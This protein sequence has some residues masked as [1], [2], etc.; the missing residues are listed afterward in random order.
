[1]PGQTRGP[2][3]ATQKEINKSNAPEVPKGPAPGSEPASTDTQMSEA[4]AAAE[5][6][7][8]KMFDEQLAKITAENAAR[9]QELEAQAKKAQSYAPVD[10]Y[11]DEE[12]DVILIHFLEDGFTAQGATWYRGQEVEVTVG[13]DRWNESLDRNGGTWFSFTERDQMERYDG[14]IMFRRGP[15]PGATYLDAEWAS[16]GP[17]VSELERADE[18]ERRRQRQAPRLPSDFT[19]E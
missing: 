7:I 9:I 17:P 3:K 10:K 4:I 15:W 18:L 13:D 1:M 19:Q 14:R 5:A 2:R 12:G 16:D 8:Q 11:E 6:R